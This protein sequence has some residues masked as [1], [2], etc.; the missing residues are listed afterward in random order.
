[1]KKYL[2]ALTL[3]FLA[4][5]TNTD[6]DAQMPYNVAIQSQAY[7]PLTGTT[8]IS[9]STPWTDTSNF[10][11]PLGFKFKIGNDTTANL[12]L[13][14][15]NVMGTDTTGLVSGFSFVGTSLIDRGTAGGTSKSPIRYNMSGPVGKRIFKLEYMNAGFSDENHIY[16]TLDD[17]LNMQVWLR[18]D[19]N[20][21]EMHFGPAKISHYSDYFFFGGPM[22]GYV[23]NMNHDALTFEKIYLLKGSP[24]APTI[25]SATA[26]VMI[27]P[28]LSSY[29]ANGTVYR[30]IPKDIPKPTTYTAHT[31]QAAGVNVYPTRCG[32]RLFVESQQAANY[33]IISLI[34]NVVQTGE[35][36]NGLNTLDVGNL[37]AGMYVIVVRNDSFY[38]SYKFI[39]Q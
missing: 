31:V 27:F 37:T 35:I 24:T 38:D 11:V 12:N 21:V 28:A 20:I 22:L 3:G 9:G 2:A 4:N 19:S 23:R 29:P 6:A 26:A 16:S 32:D 1:M 30:F 33:K 25:D 36:R 14:G 10:S 39:K 18:E 17:S 34:G 15:I 5:I 7:T 13:L 8:N